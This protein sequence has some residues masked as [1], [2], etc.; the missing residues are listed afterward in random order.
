MSSTIP[1]GWNVD[2]HDGNG[3]SMSGTSAG[4]G[5]WDLDVV[6]NTQTSIACVELPYFSKER[7][8]Q[9]TKP[10]RESLIKLLTGM[11]ND[12][13]PL[14]FRDE[15]EKD[16]VT[17]DPYYKVA[18]GWSTLSGGRR[19]YIHL[20]PADFVVKLKRAASCVPMVR[21]TRVFVVDA[22]GNKRQVTVDELT[23]MDIKVQ[24]VPNLYKQAS[25]TSSGAASSSSAGSSSLDVLNIMEK[26]TALE[27]QIA[28]MKAL[29]EQVA[30]T[31]AASMA[32][33]RAA[34]PAPAV[35]PTP[36]SAVVV[37]EEEDEPVRVSG[38]ARGKRVRDE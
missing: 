38:R 24:A 32:T 30:A 1:S 27:Q 25:G 21:A 31:A 22:Q 16:R 4:A 7:P 9:G 11:C 13:S 34:P 12:I 2:A 37:E 19:P 36:P 10:A 17:P 23:A 18:P 6:V 26:Q 20:A 28:T 15:T 33:A 8:L 14:N 35:E 3:S 5:V 29:M